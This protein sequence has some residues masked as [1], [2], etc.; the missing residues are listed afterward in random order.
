MASEV[1][2]HGHILGVSTCPRRRGHGTPRDPHNPKKTTPPACGRSAR[3]GA[4]VYAPAQ[5]IADQTPSSAA[6][7][8][9]LGASGR[10]VAAS[11]RG[12]RRPRSPSRG[13]NRRGGGPS[14][15]ASPASVGGPA[16]RSA[17]GPRSPSG[18]VGGRRKRRPSGRPSGGPGRP[19]GGPPG[20][21][22]RPS[23]GP[24]GPRRSPISPIK[25]LN[26]SRL[27]SPLPSASNRPNNRIG[28]PRGGA[29]GP[30]A[31]SAARGS[32][33]SPPRS[34]R[35]SRA[36]SPRG[37]SPSRSPTASRSPRR[38]RIRSPK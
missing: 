35:P 10:S 15:S 14:R 26:S 24:P 9:Y 7:A 2:R 21:N 28:S 32:R 13:R 31:S 3:M 6:G 33:R 20:P 23:G 29:A 25:R 34:V 16:G 1:C 22:R 18:G 17:S 5:R 38:W 12:G 4:A 8:S 11:S 30:R 37:A 36:R 19:S 27:S